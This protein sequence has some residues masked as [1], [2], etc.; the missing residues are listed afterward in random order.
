MKTKTEFH[1]KWQPLSANY[2]QRLQQIAPLMPF[3]ASLADGSLHKNT[4][5]LP[6]A[7]LQHFSEV[8]L[9]QQ[10]SSTAYPNTVHKQLQKSFIGNSL[11]VNQQPISEQ[12]WI[13][14]Q[15]WHNNLN[16]DQ[17]GSPF[18]LCFRLNEATSNNGVDWSLEILLQAK[19]IPSFMINLAEFWQDKMVKNALFNK[20]F[21]TSI[22][23][24]L[25]LQLGYA[26][27]IYPLLE[28]T[29]AQNMQQQ[30]II[31]TTD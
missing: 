26:C 24:N 23:R 1:S 6:I 28:Q 14:W 30:L 5:L 29:F 12:E 21:G 25:L 16:Y 7:V 13:L 15:V 3:S 18:Q 27:R 8:V 20:M 22:E 11:N 9:N 4:D 19:A 17:F 2:Q 31:L 10:I